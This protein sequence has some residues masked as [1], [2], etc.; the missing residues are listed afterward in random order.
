MITVE[1][2]EDNTLIHQAFMDP[3]NFK[4]MRD[5]SC[6]PDPSGYD[7]P[8]GKMRLL[9]SIFLKAVV[10]GKFGGVWW[11]VRQGTVIDVHTALMQNCRGRK[12]V[13]AAKKGIQWVWDHTDATEIRSY[14]WSD[15]PAVAWFCRIMGLKPVETKPWQA[16]RDG[17]PVNI[18]WFSLKREDV[19]P[20]LPDHS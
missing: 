4:A 12:A 5:D 14:A 19:S 6:P 8:V 2:T 17:R 20:C 11:L 3:D 13:E 9:P 15:S 18:T 16:T 10:D 1:Q 7:D